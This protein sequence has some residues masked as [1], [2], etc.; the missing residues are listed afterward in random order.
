MRAP[1]IRCAPISL[2]KIVE[3]DIGGKARQFLYRLKPVRVSSPNRMKQ[4]KSAILLIE[5]QKQWTDKGLYNWLI[6]KQLKQRKVLENT[7]ELVEI[8][9]AHV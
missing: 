5:F 9:R 7:K 1:K 3:K 8:G 6:K 2:S 4:S